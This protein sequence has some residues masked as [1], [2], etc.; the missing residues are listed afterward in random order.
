MPR[1]RSPRGPEGRLGRFHPQGWLSA[2]L[3]I[4]GLQ[5]HHPISACGSTGRAPRVLTQRSSGVC[6]SVSPPLAGT[7]DTRF[8]THVLQCDLIYTNTQ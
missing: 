2:P 5:T 3:S 8:R 7:P 1:L 6:V 4:P